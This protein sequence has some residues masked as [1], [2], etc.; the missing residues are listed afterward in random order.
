MAATDNND[1]EPVG[2]LHGECAYSG[3]AGRRRILR[4]LAE[5]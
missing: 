2:I 4:Q 3:K 5:K 1:V